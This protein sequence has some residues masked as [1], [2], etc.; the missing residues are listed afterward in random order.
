[1]EGPRTV[2]EVESLVFLAARGQP[3]FEAAH[4]TWLEDD[5]SWFIR[6]HEER[7]GAPPRIIGL[8]HAY[9]LP[10]M[11]SRVELLAFEDQPLPALEQYAEALRAQLRAE[12]FQEEWT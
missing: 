6:W 2:K 11:A 7:D 5:R 1:M 9:Q 4:R 12:D 3:G 10:E 8:V